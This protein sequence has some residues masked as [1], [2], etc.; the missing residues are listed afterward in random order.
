MIQ[1]VSS[2]LHPQTIIHTAPA[3]TPVNPLY[4]GQEER[5]EVRDRQ[6][7]TTAARKALETD[8][9]SSHSRW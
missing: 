1:I 5:G 6:A 3:W 9:T 4:Q 7:C 2:K 8:Q